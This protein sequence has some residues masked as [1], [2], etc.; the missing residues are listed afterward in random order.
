MVSVSSPGHESALAEAQG[1]VAD[2]EG[3][4]DVD[5][6]QLAGAHQAASQIDVVWGRRWVPAGV[7][8][9]DE[10]SSSPVED[11]EAEDLA[12]V[13]DGGA[14]AADT[15]HLGAYDVVLG[16]EEDGDETLL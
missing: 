16:V 9:R 2:D 11:G 8:V 5:A 13:H 6:E 1:R 15:D 7:V 10:D 12:R 14:E 3:V 4:Q